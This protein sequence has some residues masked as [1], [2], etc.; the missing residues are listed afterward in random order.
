MLTIGDFR[1]QSAQEH[2]KDNL[3]AIDS[4]D[5][6]FLV[7]EQSVA[8]LPELRV[9]IWPRPSVNGDHLIWAWNWRTAHPGPDVGNPVHGP[10]IRIK[11]GGGRTEHDTLYGSIAEAAEAAICSIDDYLK[12]ELPAERRLEEQR[13]LEE[14]ERKDSIQEQ[15]NGFLNE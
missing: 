9:R 12:S 2:G 14:Q 5:S 6:V 1:K 10:D 7:P 13:A 4:E 8:D 15:V 11:F 3:D